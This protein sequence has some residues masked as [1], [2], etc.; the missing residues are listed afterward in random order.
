MRNTLI[1]TIAFAAGA[2]I[3]SAVTWKLI[4]TKYERIAQEEIDSVKATFSNRQSEP[5]DGDTESESVKYLEHVAK[6]FAEGLYA[7]MTGSQLD[8]KGYAEQLQEMEYVDYSSNSKPKDTPKKLDDKTAPYVIKPEEFG[9]MDGYQ[10]FSLTYYAD[11]VLAD[12]YDN[13]VDDVDGTVGCDSLTKFG[14]Y[15]PEAVFVR[16][17]KLKHDYEILLDRRKFIDVV[18]DSPHKAEDEWDETM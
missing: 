2:A 16:N 4:K 12:D 14:L 13:I 7:G 15:E 1:N 18:S 3:G 11:D 8:I 10:E 17:D 9:T 5:I 6:P